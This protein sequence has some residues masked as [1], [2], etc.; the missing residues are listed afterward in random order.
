[1][2]R[3]MVVIVL[4]LLAG[5]STAKPSAAPTPAPSGSTRPTTSAPAAGGSGSRETLP[6]GSSA[7]GLGTPESVLDGTRTLVTTA[8]R[9]SQP[10]ARSAPPT[11]SGYVWGAAEVQTCLTPDDADTAFSIFSDQWRLVY[12]NDAQASASSITY[13][14]FPTP[15]FHAAD[16]VGSSGCSKGEILFPVPADTRPIRLESST[17]DGLAVIAWAVK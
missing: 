9:Y 13:A 2:R 3:L 5:C 10:V 15:I 4:A 12:A 17:P 7:D 1:M 11:H 6:V 14:P 16:E 8:Y